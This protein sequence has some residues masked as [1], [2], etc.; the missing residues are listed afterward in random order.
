MRGRVKWFDNARGWGFLVLDDGREVFVH[1]KDIAGAGGFRALRAR[2][3][4]ECDVAERERGA[5]AANV[6]RR[7]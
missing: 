3:E 1:W 7:A 4:V 5:H 2:E 6:R